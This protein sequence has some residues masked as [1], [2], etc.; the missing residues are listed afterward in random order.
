M[1]KDKLNNMIGYSGFNPN[2]KAEK[3]SKTKRT[4][5]GLDVLKEKKKEPNALMECPNCKAELPH[6]SESKIIKC[7]ECGKRIQF[8]GDSKSDVRKMR[9]LEAKEKKSEYTMLG[10]E[11]K[12][13]TNPLFGYAAVRDQQ[14]KKIGPFSSF[15]KMK[16]PPTPKERPILNAGIYI[17]T[18][19]VRGYINR[20][21][22][23]TVFVESLDEPMKIVEVK[24]K[25]A[26]KLTKEKKDEIKKFSESED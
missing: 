14:I 20:I 15:T 26:V 5:V 9:V 11:K 17:E 6:N 24:L 10:P 4:E 21:E 7:K 8:Y 1:S 19:S 18:E 13:D 2:W 23:S 12:E 16:D 25:D 22:G 3:V